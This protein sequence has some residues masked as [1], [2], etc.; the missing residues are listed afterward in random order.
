MADSLLDLKT[1]IEQ[2]TI[3]IDGVQYE[4]LHPDQLGV[5]DF[6]RLSTMA[7]GVSALMKKSPDEITDGDAAELTGI[8]ND[9]TDRIMVGVPD[10]MRAKLTESQRLA[11]AEVFMTLP[12]AQSR[13]ARKTRSQK[14]S[15]SGGS[16]PR[17][18]ASGSTAEVRP[19]G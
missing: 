19:D 15:R 6:Q 3:K 1:L 10:D 4:I 8:I 7:G 5:L 17:S 18:D 14:A 13:K 11:V 12:R 2:P 16:R 9:L